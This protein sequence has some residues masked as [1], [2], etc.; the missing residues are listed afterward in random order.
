M[1]DTR[2]LSFEKI[3]GGRQTPWPVHDFVRLATAAEARSVGGEDVSVA[4]MSVE[5]VSAVG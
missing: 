5:D 2:A 1:N 3:K 4:G